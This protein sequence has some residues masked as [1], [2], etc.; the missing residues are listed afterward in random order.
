MVCE[1]RPKHSTLSMC[2]HYKSVTLF[3]KFIIFRRPN[4]YQAFTMERAYVSPHIEKILNSTHGVELLIQVIK[5]RAKIDKG[6]QVHIE[7][8]GVALEVHKTNSLVDPIA[9]KKADQ[10]CNTTD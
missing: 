3:Q 8:D 9:E 4:H 2:K 1:A 6:E 5:N 10:V 7:V